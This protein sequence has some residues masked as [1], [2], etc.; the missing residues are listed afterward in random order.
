M[1][2]REV[3]ILECDFCG[4]DENDVVISTHVLEVDGHA[5][6]FETC[7]ACW[8]KKVMRVM[9]PLSQRGRPLK[10][11]SRRPAAKPVE[12][13]PWPGTAWEFTAHALQRLGE[14]RITPLDAVAVAENPS[15]THPGRP[16]GNPGAKMF[17]RDNLK[18]VADPDRRVVFTVAYR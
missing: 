5:V 18:V 6:E 10:K 4:I 7:D 3:I 9:A 16:D 1:A 2:S 15:T 8:D 13:V 12:A 17:W 11:R 14:R